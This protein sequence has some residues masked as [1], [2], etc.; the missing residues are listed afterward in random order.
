MNS[1]DEAFSVFK[2]EFADLGT[3]DE[4]KIRFRG[5]APKYHPDTSGEPHY[6]FSAF[7]EAYNRRIEFLRVWGDVR[8]ER[9]K[10]HR[11]EHVEDDPVTRKIK[12]AIESAVGYNLNIT[13]LG[14]WVWAW[15]EYEGGHL[16]QEPS[17]YGDDLCKHFEKHG[18]AW[19]YKRKKWYNATKTSFRY[20][21]T[22]EV[23]HDFDTWDDMK[24]QMDSRDVKKQED[25]KQL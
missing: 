1:Y 15:R 20:E 24:D 9:K 18:W 5:N 2:A 6:I 11:K 7:Q 10:R 12:E 16:P 14:D 3:V 25:T 22:G 8:G 4:C 23:A 21:A 17:A 13:V 19:S